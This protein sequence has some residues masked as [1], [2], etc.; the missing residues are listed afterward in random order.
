MSQFCSGSNVH[1]NLGD[2]GVPSIAENN[3]INTGKRLGGALGPG[4]PGR[5]IVRRNLPTS[6]AA[7][8]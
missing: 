1:G 2:R 3:Y 8:S 7:A 6:G 4:T 5:W